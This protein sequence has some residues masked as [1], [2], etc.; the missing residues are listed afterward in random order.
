M[1]L[2][3]GTIRAALPLTLRDPED[4]KSQ[5]HY[6]RRVEKEMVIS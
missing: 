3:G 6:V 4:N 5:S 2:S 1:T